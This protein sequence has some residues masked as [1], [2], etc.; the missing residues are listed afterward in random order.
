M[1]LLVRHYNY[2]NR[3]KLFFDNTNKNL[4]DHFKKWKIP[5]PTTS[6]CLT[7]QIHLLN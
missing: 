5:D 1:K 7:S 2:S 3:V 4:I 6:I